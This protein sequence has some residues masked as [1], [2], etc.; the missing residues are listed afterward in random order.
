M[1]NIEVEKLHQLVRHYDED[2][3]SLYLSYPIESYW[4]CS[5]QPEVLKERLR[6]VERAKLYLHFPFCDELCYYCCCETI[7]CTN[8][9]QKD[10]YLELLE[11]ELRYKFEEKKHIVIE[12]M[13]WGGGTPTLMSIN[14]I[15]LLLDILNTYFTFIDRK[16]YRIEL[17]PDKRFVTKEKLKF[18]YECGFR[19]I[20]I[21]VQDLNSIVLNA[22]HRKTKL[23]DVQDIVCMAKELGFQIAVDICYGLPYQGLS[24]FEHTIQEI[25]KMKPQKIVLYQYAHFPYMKSLQKKILEFSIPN[26][27]IRALQ[28]KMAV[29]MLKDDYIRFGADTYIYKDTDEK[30]AWER[31]E[32]IYGFM[33]TERKTDNDL[34]GIGPS[35]VS[36]IGNTYIK[37]YVS[38]EKYRERVCPVEKM[39]DLTIDEQ[40]RHDIIE[41][42]LMVNRGIET[43]EI[44][45]LY[46]IVFD[47][48]FAPEL[49]ELKRMESRGLL[50]GVGSPEIKI[51]PYGFYFLKSISRVFDM[52]S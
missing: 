35:A 44:N 5:V 19:N 30:E 4:S 20:S 2:R 23:K 21:G 33:G 41:N 32:I 6:K 7:R 12:D 31:A 48:K 27:F 28:K 49:L 9:R 43:E 13:H 29:E 11:K 25:R 1:E 15:R 46:G 36:K 51:S 22:I 17:F 52:D 42:H 34:V 18:L 39:H 40:I 8:E 26:G 47:E 50:S 37:N 3:Q 45:R 10:E 14:Q 16:D 24:E 38:Y